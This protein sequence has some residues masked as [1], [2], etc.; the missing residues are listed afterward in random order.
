MSNPEQIEAM[1]GPEAQELAASLAVQ[2]C[3]SDRFKTDLAT[4]LG[5]TRAAVNSWFAQ[6]GKPPTIVILYLEAEIARLDAFGTL[7]MLNHTLD[8]LKNYA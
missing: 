6:G 1:A 8:G 2:L 7:Q 4:R 5:Y 3:G